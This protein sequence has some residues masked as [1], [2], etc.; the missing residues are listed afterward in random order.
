MSKPAYVVAACALAGSMLGPAVAVAAT[1]NDGD[2]FAGVGE[3]KYRVFSNGGTFKEEVD[4]GTDPSENT[5]CAFDPQDDLWTASF[6]NPAR[7]VQLTGGHPHSV[8]KTI[9][10]EARGG[11]GTESIVFARDGSFYVGNADGNR[12][13]MK[14]SAAGNFVRAF[15]VATDDRGS[16]WLDLAADQRTLF[17]TSEGNEVKRFD[18]RS[19]N[20]LSDFATLPNRPSYALR[21]L[22]RGGLL[23]ANDRNVVRLNSSGQVIKT[24][25]QSGED[26]WFALNL[27]PNRRSFWSGGLN[28]KRFYRFNIST[29]ARE[30]GPI[31]AGGRSTLAGFCVK[32]E[33]AAATG[34]DR[35]KPRVRVLGVPSGCARSTFRARIRISD[36]SSLRRVKVTRD[37][38]T[39]RTTR[40]KRFSVRVRAGR[41]PQGAHRLRVAARDSAGNLGLRSVRFF[42]CAA[43]R[44]TG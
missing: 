10:T 42:R 17:Y 29:G 20:Q 25:D 2:V 33:I 13:V 31:D 43:P 19:N 5:G 24:Y 15:N 41:L 37:G 23:V 22:P 11:D 27:D 8:L 12:D 35:T 7:V 39:V 34:K 28:S 6:K 4:N 3:G 40:R 30:I 18:V 9:D 21:L 32:G 26:D 44:F 16:D 38:R 36:A 1:W 14:F